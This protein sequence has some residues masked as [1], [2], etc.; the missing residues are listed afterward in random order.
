LY[1]FEDEIVPDL[2]ASPIKPITKAANAKIVAAL[3]QPLTQTELD[4]GEVVVVAKTRRRAP[5]KKDVTPKKKKVGNLTMYPAEE[6]PPVGYV[7]CNGDRIGV[8]HWITDV[9][10]A[11]QLLNFWSDQKA[12]VA[13]DL[14]TSAAWREVPN[15][16]WVPEE[17]QT[18]ADRP[19][20][21]TSRLF[22]QEGV[23]W[24][25]VD[26]LGSDA[27]TSTIFLLQCSVE[28]GVAVLFDMR[29]L[30]KD[31]RFMAAARRMFQECYLIGQ[32]CLFDET[33]IVTQFGVYPN[34]IFNS[35]IGHRMVTAG[36]VKGSDMGSLC[37]KYRKIK[38]DKGWQ[39]TWLAVH[40]ESPLPLEA[41]LYAA[42]DVLFL[43]DVA[44]RIYQDLIAK[45]QDQVWEELERPFMFWVT[46]ARQIGMRIDEQALGEFS[47]KMQQIL[48]DIDT[49]L[50]GLME[51]VE[52]PNSPDQ[53]GKWL[54][55]RG[56]QLTQTATG[57]VSTDEKNLSGLI[58][59]SKKPEI[60]AVAE[61][62]LDRRDAGKIQ[63]TYA[64]PLLVEHR[65]PVTGHAHSQW[66]QNEAE[67][68]RMSSEGPN[69]QNIP[70]KDP[71]YSILRD[72]FVAP[73]PVKVWIDQMTRKFL[74]VADP[75]I[76]VAYSARYISQSEAAAQGLFSELWKMKC[77]TEDYSQFEVRALADMAGERKM[78]SIFEQSYEVNQKLRFYC[79]ENGIVFR[80][81]GGLKDAY[82]EWVKAVADGKQEKAA[83]YFEAASAWMQL[84][85]AH[86]TVGKLLMELKVLDFHTQ[87]AAALFCD[88]DVTKVDKLMR[89]IAKCFHPD[90]EAL[91]PNG[92]RRIA[93]L[94]TKDIVLQAVPGKDGEVTFEWVLPTE[95]FTMKHPSEKIVHL[96]NEGI[97]LRVTP[98]HRMLYWTCKGNHHVCMPEEFPG[99][100]ARWANAGKI[101]SASYLEI[102]ETL[103]RLAV[104]TQADGS[105]Q[106]GM[107]RFG[108]TK[109]RKIQRLRALLNQSGLSYVEGKNASGVVTFRISTESSRV[110][111]DLLDEKCLPWDWLELTE[112][113]R[114]VVLDEA[115]YWDSTK[116][117]G[118]TSY[119]F[120]STHYQNVDV[121]QA[122]AAITG[123][124]S[125]FTS[126][127]DGMKHL[128][129]KDHAYTKGG[130]LNAV[131]EDYDGEVACIS[132]PS[133]FIL[134]RDGGVPIVAGQTVNFGIPYGR[135]AQGIAEG[136]KVDMDKAQEILDK[137]FNVYR[138]VKRWLD[139]IRNQV[140]TQGYTETP[141][142]R[143]RFYPLQSVQEIFQ[144]LAEV[145]A[146]PDP[147]QQK[148]WEGWCEK[149]Q[150]RD[151]GVMARKMNRRNLAAAQRAATN[152]PIQG[153]NADATKS[154]TIIA[155]PRLYALNP[156][157]AITMWVHDEIVAVA[158][159]HLAEQASEIQMESMIAGAK[160]YV[161][162]CPIEVSCA[163]SDRWEK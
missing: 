96:K 7:T 13:F 161:K 159:E 90:T 101:D 149:W 77:I 68:G 81:V 83:K 119:R 102:N 144:D 114:E 89:N 82:E 133:T 24:K 157:C 28:D 147:A 103:L 44:K 98:D 12:W 128:S 131:V 52:N 53:L 55:S 35:A 15:M 10:Q 117:K 93:D 61:T 104:A 26:P 153:C 132:V 109:E 64:G 84:D 18:E 145:Q 79:S 76:A 137:Y 110:I 129:V 87:T 163:I 156:L 25:E 59:K 41:L 136:V 97:D 126:D 100:A 21:R 72:A 58:T 56:A 43:L 73:L 50:R 23:K 86:P 99:K 39:K 124:K 95:V 78:L 111:R 113:L 27:W 74:G 162:R 80:S 3:N 22:K 42:G 33:F 152:A 31:E 92:W 1:D 6:I 148:K 139:M 40:P 138:S 143:R 62:V 65:N 47:S 122:I 141:G 158:P 135:G 140:Q 130:N 75:A 85:K 2:A 106:A 105:Y 146:D 63:N 16:L 91:T 118:C 160:L 51:G 9:E 49:K 125:R 69:L 112:T 150:T 60:V 8:Y 11:I 38:L 29:T 46:R 54:I 37:W 116:P 155:G 123:R 5:V 151:P 108:F 36:S 88:G 4:L 14:E 121:L 115:Q 48:S 20:I 134:V 70:A 71:R 32:N 94:T 67:T 45:G 19:L 66:N 107:I 34:V 120:D 30:M 154:A 142:G 57:K 127:P 17:G